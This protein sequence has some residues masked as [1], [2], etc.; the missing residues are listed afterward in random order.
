MD[1]ID[2]LTHKFKRAKS[3]ERPGILHGVYKQLVASNK[4]K[5]TN[6][7]FRNLS[8]NNSSETYN[9]A[10]TVAE[11]L[12]KY[13]M[14]NHANK[15][16]E[17]YSGVPREPQKS[18]TEAP[19]ILGDQKTIEE[20]CSSGDAGINIAALGA[21]AAANIHV[22]QAEKQPAKLKFL[23]PTSNQF[24]FDNVTYKIIK[25]LEEKNFNV[26]GIQV[27]FHNYGPNNSYKKVDTIEGDD[28]R[29]W[30]CRVQGKAD[31][32]WNDTAAVTELNI[33]GKELH[34]HEDN[35]GPTFYLYVGKNWEAD[36]HNFIH[37]PK[38]NSKLRG[39]PK[40]YLQFSGS[41]QKSR[42]GVTYRGKIA[43][44]LAHTNDL[45]REYDPT[46]NEPKYF[47]T[48]KV[49][50]EFTEFFEKKLEQII[51]LENSKK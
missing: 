19:N 1:A 25:A 18:W 36:K 51:G 42:G 24:P 50:E 49:F 4:G 15:L 21:I 47:E 11:Q 37:G 48:H 40:T 33:P 26:P 13:G 12:D 20:L 31:P 30:F 27:E 3:S 7:V 6:G 14:P 44:F 34:V 8:E 5:K 43:P 16:R 39:E 10:H 45:E 28:F 17:E 38:V 32:D 22:R 23:Y 46:G 35:S 2:S 9:L 41:W 29:L